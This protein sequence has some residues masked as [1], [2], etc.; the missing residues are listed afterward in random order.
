M[1]HFRFVPDQTNIQFMRGRHVAFFVSLILIIGSFV[2][3]AVKGL[4]YGIDFRGG[5]LIEVKTPLGTSIAEMRDSLGTLGL[6]R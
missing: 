6:V 2:A 4:N 5:I 1:R 3:F